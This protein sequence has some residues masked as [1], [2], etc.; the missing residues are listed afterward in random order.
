ML[1]FTC[2]NFIVPLL[3][4]ELKVNT[5]KTIVLPIALYDC[6]TWSFTLR[7]EH[8]LRVY[9]N[10][11]LR[12]IFGAKRDEITG[13]RR[14][15]HNSELY[16]LYSSPNIIR[17]LKSGRLTWAGHVARMEQSRNAYRVLV[18]KPEGKRPLGRPRQWEDNIKMDLRKLGCD[19]RDW[20]ALAE[21]RDQWRVNVRTVTNLRVP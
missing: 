11:V 3:S 16:A 2:E 19:P 17:S 1:L 14:K 6:D 13:E 10:K 8:R 18:R 7:E 15:L 12:K 20:I 4:K 5:Y 9:A 21:D